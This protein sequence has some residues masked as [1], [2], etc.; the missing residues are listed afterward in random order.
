[1]H[2]PYLGRP[3]QRYLSKVAQQKLNLA[4]QV[5]VPTVT[6]FH[7]LLES[8]VRSDILQAM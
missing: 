1:M 7:L 6:H 5:Q 2:A 8:L 3:L 4:V